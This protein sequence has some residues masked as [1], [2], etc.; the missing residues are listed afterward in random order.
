VNEDDTR[1]REQIRALVVAYAE[2]LDAGDLDGVAAL[3]ERGQFRSDR[4]GAPRVGT[5][6]VRAVYEP[7]VLYDDGTPRTKHVLGNVQVDVDPA[8]GVGQASCTFTVVQASPGGPLRSVLAGRYIDRFERHHDGWWFAE[9][10]VHSDLIGDLS[11]H[12]RRG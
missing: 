4:G 11:V 9:R 10:M 3:F 8:T 12:M 6:E 7:V 2:R 5:A 1:D